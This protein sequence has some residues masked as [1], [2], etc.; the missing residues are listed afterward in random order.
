MFLPQRAVTGGGDCVQEVETIGE[1]QVVEFLL[2]DLSDESRSRI[3]ERF[4]ADDRFYEQL[5][6]IQEELAD[7]YLHNNLSQHERA[8]FEENFLKSPRRRQRVEFARAFSRALTN[9]EDR[10][11]VMPATKVRWFESLRFF[12]T[13]PVRL[14]A[15]ASA[16][17]L[18]LLV[19]AGWL[20]VEN[21]RLSTRVQ[22]VRQEK[23]SLAQQVGV[24]DAAATRKQQ[25]LER[26]IASLRS[27][28]SEM[29]TA[30]AQ[31]ERELEVLK[32]ARA[33]DRS[34]NVS[35]AIASFVLQPGLTRGTDEPERL[36]IPADA[37]SVQLQLD[38][39]REENF[40]SYV[41]E[42][43]TARGNLAWSKSGLVVQQTSYGRAVT[44]AIPA[45]VI[46][47]GE[48]E[49]TLN[50]ISS[51]KAQPVGYYYFIAINR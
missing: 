46:S 44:L 13:P 36:I 4:F 23:D 22:Q 2:G 34:A 50:G 16:V 7:D 19:C 9:S 15:V 41:A 27:Q 28:G 12:F 25:D 35:P 3:E 21:R 37:R 30:I 14:P 40:Q 39:E 10:F 18:G 8:R 51:G 29:E 49:I 6:A 1:R 45:S 31:K 42:I 20:L 32:R 5:L 11:V 47:N 33:S 43:R 24:N 38:L 26:E 48:Y 17:V